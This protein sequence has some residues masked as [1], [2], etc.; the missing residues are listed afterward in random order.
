NR[1]YKI[2]GVVSYDHAIIDIRSE[3]QRN[4]LTRSSG[5]GTDSESPGI[6]RDTPISD[7]PNARSEGAG[8]GAEMCEIVAAYRG[9]VRVGHDEAGV[10]DRRAKCVRER[11]PHVTRSRAEHFEPPVSHG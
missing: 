4:D 3:I 7:A 6:R 2:Y 9:D 5:S 8:V 1:S 10:S 11:T